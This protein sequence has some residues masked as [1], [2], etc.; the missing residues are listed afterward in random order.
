MKNTSVQQPL[1]IQPSP[2]PEQLTCLG[3]VEGEMTR[4]DRCRCKARRADRRSALNRSSVPAVFLGAPPRD[5]Q[6]SEPLLETRNMMLKQNC[7]LDRR[8]H[9]G[10]RPTQICGFL[11]MITATPDLLRHPAD[12]TSIQSIID[13]CLRSL[14]ATQGGR[15]P[16]IRFPLA[17]WALSGRVAYVE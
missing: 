15:S 6:F 1:S 9:L 12:P 13:S 5:L 4:K 7:H 16:P 11:W 2:F 10:L 14:L 8:S 3:Q 17:P